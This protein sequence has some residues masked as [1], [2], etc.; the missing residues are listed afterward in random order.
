[1]S[2]EEFQ[3]SLPPGT[4]VVDSEH[5]KVYTIPGNADVVLTDFSK[6]GRELVA[7]G[8]KT[9]GMETNGLRRILMGVTLLVIVVLLLLT[10]RKHFQQR[11]SVP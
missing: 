2:D 10:V 3:A 9:N 6:I 11:H 5:N 1:V 7:S 4:Y 8:S